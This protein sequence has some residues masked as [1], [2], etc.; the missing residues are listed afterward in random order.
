MRITSGNWIL[1][2]AVTLY[3]AAWQQAGTAQ[4]APPVILQV[5][6]ENM[7]QYFGDTSDPSKF[8]T[9]ANPTSA[10][11]RT[12]DAAVLMADIVA[13]N[14]KPAKGIWVARFQSVPLRLTPSPSMAIADVVRSGPGDETYEILQPDGTPVGTVVSLGLFG[15][16]P[17]PGTP[18]ALTTGNHAIVGGTGAFAGVRGEDGGGTPILP[19]RNASFSEDP[20]N[21]RV[22]GGGKMRFT[23][24]L[25]PLTRPE[26]VST[27]GEPAIFHSTD[28]TLVT[29]NNPAKPGEMLSL[30]ATGLGPV[31]PGVDPG[32]PFP[33]DPPSTVNSP[34]EVIVNG[35][36]AEMVGA[37]GYPGSLD[38]YRVDFRIPAGA[39][40]GSA[41]VQLTAAWIP[42]SSISIA[43][44]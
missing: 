41:S 20:A 7:V 36:P 24:H 10:M 5:D 34:V 14:G 1:V 31:R 30:I 44:Q 11:S 32:K 16:T 40:S 35:A 21:R 33:A 3:A 22:N 9:N 39:E 17:A 6:I 38:A 13:V 29:T 28:F 15:G 12:F 27:A 19:A 23:L 18:A 37:V 2:A 8:A 43:V 25:V 4:T 26:I 42:S